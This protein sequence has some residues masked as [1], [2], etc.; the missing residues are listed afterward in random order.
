MTPATV[1]SSCVARSAIAAVFSGLCPSVRA[2]CSA[3]SSRV[4]GGPERQAA[5][6]VVQVAYGEGFEPLLDVTNRLPEPARY[7]G[8]R[9]PPRTPL[10]VIRDPR[11]E[12]SMGRGDRRRVATGVATE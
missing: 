10:C 4:A 12:A 3:A 6:A 5:R 1:A 2:R 9:P 7:H 11:A 8:R